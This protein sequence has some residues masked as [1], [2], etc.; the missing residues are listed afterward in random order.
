MMTRVTLLSVLLFAAKA[1]ADGFLYPDA[2]A[3]MS[4]R[5]GDT[6]NVS[7]TIS[8]SQPYLELFCGYVAM[9]KHSLLSVEHLSPLMHLVSV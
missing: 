2:S 9:R 5:I 6:V 8:Y 3:A 1:V 4:F 7:W